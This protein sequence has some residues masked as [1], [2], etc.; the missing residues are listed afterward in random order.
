MCGEPLPY[1]AI[2]ADKRPFSRM[3]RELK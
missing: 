3:A 2:T 1:L